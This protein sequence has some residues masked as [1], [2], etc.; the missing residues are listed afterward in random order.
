MNYLYTLGS[1]R[2][3]YPSANVIQDVREILFVLCLY[4]FIFDEYKI[5]AVLSSR[6]ITEHFMLNFAVQTVTMQISLLYVI[7]SQS[8]P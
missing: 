4:F 1:C 7:S 3:Q 6:P 5:M 2:R 8:L